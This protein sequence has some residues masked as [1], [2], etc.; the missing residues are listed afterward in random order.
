MTQKI[1]KWWQ[2]ITFWNKLRGTLT[3]I[4]VLV[5]AEMVREGAHFGWN[6]FA[7]ALT[8]LSIVITNW[9][10]DKDGD[11]TADIFQKPK[12]TA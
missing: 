7:L 1:V 4:G 10:E 5:Q 9:F 11:G 12:P 6:L 2:R 8:G 3:A